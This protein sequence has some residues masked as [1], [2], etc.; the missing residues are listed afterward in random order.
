M[1]NLTGR[2]HGNEKIGKVIGVVQD[3][4]N[5]IQKKVDNSAEW[6]PGLIGPGNVL[7]PVVSTVA[8]R[9]RKRAIIAV[10]LGI[11]AV[12][13]AAIGSVAVTSLV[14][15][16][17]LEGEFAR[18]Q[19]E[20]VSLKQNDEKLAKVLNETVDGL[21]VVQDALAELSSD[22]DTLVDIFYLQA[23]L[24]NI[25]QDINFYLECVH[26]QADVIQ[27]AAQGKVVP[28]LLPLGTLEKSLKD[29]AYKF[30]LKPLFSGGSL[31]DYYGILE[32]I[33]ATTG[34]VVKIPMATDHK[35]HFYRVSP[36]PTFYND[37][38]MMVEEDET[39][40]V[41]SERYYACIA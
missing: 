38:I 14:K 7:Q 12:A 3:S 26:T 11:L 18:Q 29:A 1:K 17:N 22:F 23:L 19:G 33:L 8:P 25:E 2:T 36:F 10:G 24:T 21:N 9:R 15:V 28:K 31:W 40:L 16:T 34:I 13:I 20:I 6:F 35:F 4:V 32:G 37:H 27:A 5:R 39:N 30:H 41:Y